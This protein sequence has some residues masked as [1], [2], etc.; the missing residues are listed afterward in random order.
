[1]VDEV[2]VCLLGSEKAPVVHRVAVGPQRSKA[3]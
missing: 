1:M 2:E 3:G